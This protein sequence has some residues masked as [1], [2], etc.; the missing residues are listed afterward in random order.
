[1]KN[2]TGILTLLMLT[3]NTYAADDYVVRTKIFDGENLVASPAM[4][5]A[6]KQETTATVSGSYDLKLSI[7][8]AGENTANVN[9]NLTIG[10]EHLAP[11][12]LVEYDKESTITIKGKSISILVS[13]LSS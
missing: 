10:S 4:Q 6:A 7:E 5:I 11:S 1:M 3:S 13:K 9:T 12:M 8:P 2:I